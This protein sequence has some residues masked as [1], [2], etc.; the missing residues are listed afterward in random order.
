MHCSILLRAGSYEAPSSVCL[1]LGAVPLATIETA[2]AYIK[3]MH[4]YIHFKDLNI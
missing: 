1:I 3:N 2:S 4:I